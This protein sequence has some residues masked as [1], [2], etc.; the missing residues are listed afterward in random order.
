[1]ILNCPRCGTKF[2]KLE[3]LREDRNVSRCTECGLLIIDKRH[4]TSQRMTEMASSDQPAFKDLRESRVF[5]MKDRYGDT[6]L[7][8]IDESGKIR[9]YNKCMACGKVIEGIIYTYHDEESHRLLHLCKK[10]AQ[11]QDNK[12]FKKFFHTDKDFYV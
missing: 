1:M 5:G 2:P 7:V 12:D 3:R 11:D 8:I 4:C 10:C 6:C 9:P